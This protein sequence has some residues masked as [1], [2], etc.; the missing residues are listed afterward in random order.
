MNLI[1]RHPV[2]MGLIIVVSAA[3]GAG[4][5]HWLL[6]GASA[7]QD[8]SQSASQN[9]SQNASQGSMEPEAKTPLYWVAPMDPNYRRDQPGRSPMGMALVPVY[10]QAPDRSSGL[11]L[12]RIA[13]EVMHQLGVRTAPV[14]RRQLQTD[15]VTTGFVQYDETKLVHIH[16]RVSGWVEKLYVTAAGDP[17]EADMP[18]YTLYAP[19]LVNAQEELVIALKRANPP[20]IAAAEARLQA[21]Q[22]P[23]SAIQSLKKTLSVR[24]TVAFYA[25]QSGVVDR[26]NIRE[27]FFVDP[28]TTL[29]SIGQ[30]ESVW[31]GVDIPEQQAA[32]VKTGD[33]ITMTLDH[34]PGAVWQGTVGFIYPTLDPETRTLRARV[35]LDNRD[36]KLKPN[37][38]AKVVIHRRG[39]VAQR[40]IPKDALIRTGQIDRAVLALGGGRFQSVVVTVGQMDD[41]GAEILSGLS[42]GDQV[43][44]H[45]QFLIDSESNKGAEFARMEGALPDTPQQPSNSHGAHHGDHLML[46]EASKSTNAGR[47]AQPEG[48]TSS[49]PKDLDGAD[50]AK[51][52]RPGLESA[53]PKMTTGLQSPH[54]DHAD[55]A[56]HAGH[57]APTAPQSLESHHHPGAKQA[58]PAHPD[59]DAVEAPSGHTDPS[60]DASKQDHSAQAPPTAS[61]SSAV[62]SSL[63]DVGLLGQISVRSGRAGA[64]S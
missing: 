7:R 51:H 34:F 21:L 46:P 30:L 58:E 41:L 1:R 26:L 18:L 22:V 17:V 16:P 33:A 14:T 48:D 64:R 54:G 6:G 44:T 23:D 3:L 15:L 42:L 25:A 63:T 5:N 4:V 20:L 8:A 60:Q 55:H 28:A 50:H 61:A 53:M 40:V 10:E 56:E 37:M 39:E 24:Q 45:A 49:A 12:V 52:S 29:M 19:E 47:P 27:G 32:L 57:A 38:F 43:V 11:A 62:E 36:L 59:H 13:P 2:V 31:V 9:A 35:V